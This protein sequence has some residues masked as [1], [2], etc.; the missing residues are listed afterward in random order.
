MDDATW[1]RKHCTQTV[2][3]WPAAIREYGIERRASPRRND[4]KSAYI[5]NSY[6]ER[7]S[8][9][10]QDT[11]G[12]RVRVDVLTD[13]RNL[14]PDPGIPVRSTSND[15]WDVDVISV[16]GQPY[17][18]AVMSVPVPPEPLESLQDQLSA[19]TGGLLPADVVRPAI[20][21]QLPK[22]STNSTVDDGSIGVYSHG[23]HGPPPYSL[24]YYK[25]AEYARYWSD[26][27]SGNRYNSSYKRFDNNCTN[28]LSQALFA[29]GWRQINGSYGN[30]NDTGIWDYDL[31]YYWNPSYTWTASSYLAY[32]SMRRSWNLGNIWNG[33]IGDI[34]MTDWDPNGRSD[35]KIDHAMM[36]SGSDSNGPRISQNSPHRR[37]IPLQMSI[38]L[39]KNQGK[40]RII[41]Y[42]FRT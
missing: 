33:L 2:K 42:G 34:L 21:D 26:T 28:F 19:E 25:M 29:G 10:L 11:T 38:A 30:R 4:S 22:S 6:Y 35:G 13:W 3:R 27:S 16:A 37:N 24:D 20:L 41:W 32:F 14:D 7:N 1:S 9:E 5:R 39:A 23:Y 8:L 31:D 12:I 40:T 18:D 17:V 36:V 15:T